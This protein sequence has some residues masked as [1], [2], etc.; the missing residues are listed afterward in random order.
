MYLPTNPKSSSRE[1]NSRR[2]SAAASMN[3]KSFGLSQNALDSRG[4]LG[5]VLDDSSPSNCHLN[6]TTELQ[7]LDSRD[8]YKHGA[9]GRRLLCPWCISESSITPRSSNSDIFSDDSLTKF[10]FKN[11]VSRELYVLDDRLYDYIETHACAGGKHGND[12]D[13]TSEAGYLCHELL[14]P[15][16]FLRYCVKVSQLVSA[17]TD[18]DYFLD[19][20]CE[21]SSKNSLTEN[22]IKG[23]IDPASKSHD[24]QK[25]GYYRK[26]KLF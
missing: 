25:Y 14:G 24:S 17:L 19:N 3:S 21:E 2:R 10:Y 18:D 12:E 9:E 13:I 1:I 8:T 20:C 7:K 11:D 4:V 5:R 22:V 15:G 23:D 6:E 26:V 16:Q